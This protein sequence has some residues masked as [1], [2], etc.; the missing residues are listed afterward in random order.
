MVICGINKSN[1][2]ERYTYKEAQVQLHNMRKNRD[3]NLGY[4]CRKIPSLHNS[5]PKLRPLVQDAV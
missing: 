4:K 3:E 1:M 2:H 5:E